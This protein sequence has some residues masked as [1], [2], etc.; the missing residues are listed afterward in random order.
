M[1]SDVRIEFQSDATDLAAAAAAHLVSKLASRDTNSTYTLALSGGRITEAFFRQVVF[2]TSRSQLD[3]N[4]V[5]FFWADERCVPPDEDE[6]NFKL[7]QDLLLRPLGVP[8]DQVHRIKGEL[9]EGE[10]AEQASQTLREIAKETRDGQPVIDL[11]LLGM[12]EDGHAAS[13]FPGEDESWMSDP[14]P[15]RAITDSPKPPPQRVTLGYRAIAAAREVWVL[16]SGNGKSAALKDSLAE[17]RLT[18]LGRVLSMRE[19]TTIYTDIAV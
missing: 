2:Q 7:A 15:F 11:V 9:H 12:G 19:R 3:L 10:A 1:H 14:A 5:H 8:T 18:P 6:S 4:G 17:G 16:V 13:L